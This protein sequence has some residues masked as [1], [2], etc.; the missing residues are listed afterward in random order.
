LFDII[1]VENHN[2]PEDST[3]GMAAELRL[4]TA[5]FAVSFQNMLALMIVLLMVDIRSVL[6]FML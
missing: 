6:L 1:R 2:L 5:V 4:G 3:D